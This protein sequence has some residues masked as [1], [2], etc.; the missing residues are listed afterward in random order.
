MTATIINFPIDR[1]RKPASAIEAGER[2]AFQAAV[3]GH[4]ASPGASAP[5]TAMMRLALEG[6]CHSARRGAAAWL[7]VNCNI[8]VANG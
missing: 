3:A 7:E 1:C 6:T 5:I 2:A 4:T 8:T